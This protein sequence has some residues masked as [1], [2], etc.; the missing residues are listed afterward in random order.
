MLTEI[1]RF[2]DDFH[3]VILEATNIFGS[4][5]Q[6]V[7]FEAT[8][9]IDGNVA[10]L[11]ASLKK[12]GLEITKEKLEFLKK[13]IAATRALEVV[14]AHLQAAAKIAKNVNL[15]KSSS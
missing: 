3:D 2:M 11:V 8:L 6:Y 12:E 7:L 5:T 1:N 15:R 13:Y 9:L 10:P 4:D 14:R